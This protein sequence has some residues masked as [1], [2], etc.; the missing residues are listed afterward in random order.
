[1]SGWTNNAPSRLPRG[2]AGAGGL[3]GVLRELGL[4]RLPVVGHSLGAHVAT[5]Y[6][7]EHPGTISRFVI[8]DVA[9]DRDPARITGKSPTKAWPSRF[10]GLD[11]FLRA[12]E[13]AT[14]WRSRE[15]L[16][17]IWR[18]EFRREADGGWVDKATGGFLE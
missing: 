5:R 16:L 15:R 14:P 13:A 8:V 10:A 4:R 17:D 7:A 12:A 6:E 11:E 1:M 2:A 18:W 9:P 3:G